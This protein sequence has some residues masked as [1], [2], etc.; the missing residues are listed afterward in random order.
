MTTF[1]HP[2]HCGSRIW[3][4]EALL[5]KGEMIVRTFLLKMAAMLTFARMLLSFFRQ[6]V[7][8]SM[9]LSTTYPNKVGLQTIRTGVQLQDKTVV[10]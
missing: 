6:N 8:N 10:F 4:S 5:D 2:P 1:T 3:W 7:N 9:S